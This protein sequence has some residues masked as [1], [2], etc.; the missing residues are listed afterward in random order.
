MF[1]LALG[2]GAL[3]ASPLSAQSSHGAPPE[4]V[5]PWE[6]V[7]SDD[8]LVSAFVSQ[9]PPLTL[10]AESQRAARQ[11]VREGASAPFGTAP[12]WSNTLRR[13]VGGLALGQLDDQPGLDLAVGCY[14][15]NSFPPYEDWENLVYF[16][17]GS[18]LE[19]NP[20]WVSADEVS[21]GDIQV[22]DVDGDDLLDIFAANGGGSFPP[23]VIYFNSLGGLSTSPGWSSQDSVWNNYGLLFDFDRDEDLDLLTANQGRTNDPFRPMHFF[24]NDDGVLETAPSWSSAESSIQ[25]FFSTGDYDDDGWVDV[26]VSKWA[27]FESGVYRNVAGTLATT[28]AW[29][30]GDTDTDK[31]VAFAALDGTAPP[32]LALGHDPTLLYTNTAGTLAQT[33]SATGTFFGHS[34][35]RF[36]DVDDDG[37]QDLAEIHFS[38]GVINLYLNDGGTLSSAPSWSYNGAGAG[39]A[40]AFGDLNGDGRTDLVAGFSGDPSILVFYNTGVGSLDPIFEDGFEGGNTTSWTLTEP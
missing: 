5:G 1:L 38:N 8:A 34:D 16:N 31:G 7:I 39:T 33:W 14:I 11:R 17:T 2:V 30:T 24:E 37:D 19:A 40:L 4:L 27:N 25:N 12:D 6:I 35:L 10:S 32:D 28:P 23:S 18:G 22:G 21:T 36:A 15:S 26:A 9:A 20:S 13:Q 29:T 3:G